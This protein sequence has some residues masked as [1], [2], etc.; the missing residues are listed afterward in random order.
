MNAVQSINSSL[1]NEFI[2]PKLKLFFN[3]FQWKELGPRNIFT[4]EAEKRAFHE[5]QDA[6]W[7]K[8]FAKW[9]EMS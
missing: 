4:D 6:Y 5:E 3:R 7:K 8:E 1:S 9:K 2:K